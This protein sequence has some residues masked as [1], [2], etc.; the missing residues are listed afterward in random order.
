MPD[1]ETKVTVKVRGSSQISFNPLGDEYSKLELIACSDL[2]NQ[3]KYVI[4]QMPLLS[5][6][7]STLREGK[8]GEDAEKDRHLISDTLAQNK[9]MT[10]FEHIT[11]TF[12]VVAPI[13]VIREWHRHRTQSYN[14]MSMRYTSSNTNRFYIPRNWRVQS[15]A[16]KQ[17]SGNAV[18]SQEK[19]REFTEIV[20]SWYGVC[21]AEYEA[22]LKD[23]VAKELARIIL[24]VGTYSEMYATANLRN[25]YAFYELRADESAQWEIRQY[26]NAIGEILKAWFPDS[27]AAL[28]KWKTVGLANAELDEI[29]SLL[30]DVGS[31]GDILTDDQHEALIKKLEKLRRRP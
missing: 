4:D 17:G 31:C 22:L 13:F 2:I 12:R 24:P 20:R 18:F 21:Y 15:T 1:I 29:I 5:A 10:P 16:N 7:I 30:E 6:R 28:S 26:A 27:W 8:T 3:E 19:Q 25:W 14:E 11:V 23:G 9:H